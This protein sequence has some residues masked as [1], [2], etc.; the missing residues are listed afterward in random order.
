[1]PIGQPIGAP[2]GQQPG[3]ANALP[4]APA[5]PRFV[6]PPPPGMV[7]QQGNVVPLPPGVVYMQPGYGGGWVQTAAPPA[8]IVGRSYPMQ[9]W[10]RG[11][12]GGGEGKRGL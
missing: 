7:F 10:G 11:G 2:S 8:R 1:M 3:V 6:Q 9:V 4:Q 5:G 12:L